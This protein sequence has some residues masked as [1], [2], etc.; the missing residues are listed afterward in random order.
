[1]QEM[2]Q[3]DLKEIQAVTL[4]MSK[5][6]VQFCQE[7]NL[8]CYFCGGGCIGAVRNQGF[9]PWDD[10]LD[11]FM[12]RPDYEKLKKLWPQKADINRYPLLVASKT[13]NDHNSFITIRDTATTFI[14]PY[15]EDLYF[16]VRWCARRKFAKKN[17]K[18]LG[19][20]LCVILFASCS[21]KTWWSDGYRKQGSIRDFFF[22]QNSLSYLALC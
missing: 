1:M 11:F 15:Q 13:Y 9:I 20:D 14:K 22:K 10:D 12:P 8:L 5:Y 21:R 6:F 7:N 19:T 2:S 4:T 3:T 17:P 16:S 18:V